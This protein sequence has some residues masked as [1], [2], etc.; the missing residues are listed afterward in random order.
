LDITLR[1]PLHLVQQHLS[2]QLC[3][4]SYSCVNIIGDLIDE[5][6][7]KVREELIKLSKHSNN[8]RIADK[9]KH[10]AG[11]V[12]T[13]LVLFFKES[14]ENMKRNVYIDFIFFTSSRCIDSESRLMVII[15]T[16][17]DLVLVL[18]LNVE[19]PLATI[20]LKPLQRISLLEFLEKLKYRPISGSALKQVYST[21]QI[22]DH[23][24]IYLH[25]IECEKVLQL[26]ARHAYSTRRYRHFIE[27]IGLVQLLNPN[28]SA[29]VK[30]IELNEL[31]IELIRVKVEIAKDLKLDTYLCS[32]K[33]YI[34][35]KELDT[36]EVLKA[37]NNKSS[38]NEKPHK[39]S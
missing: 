24:G 26:E 29:I 5:F 28:R 33:I 35:E 36:L 18:T 39:C 8:Q 3:T 37:I 34:G 12:E 6:V 2:N 9:V 4:S 1:P 16:N 30:R 20:E 27:V 7:D 32:D 25:D 31:V 15:T 13:N 14:F 10:I 17:S 23:L 22:G 11:D 21:L 38:I 19:S